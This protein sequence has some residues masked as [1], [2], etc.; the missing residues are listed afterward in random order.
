[1]SVITGP[2]A[3]TTTGATPA[4]GIATLLKNV[5]DTMIFASIYG[6][7]GSVTLKFMGT[8]DG[9]NY[10]P[11]QAI[12]LNTGGVVN[13][14]ISVSDNT[15]RGWRVPC[16]GLTNV[17]LYIVGIGSG[18]VNAYGASGLFVNLPLNSIQQTGTVIGGAQTMTGNLT[19]ADGV[20]VPLGSSSGTKFGTATSQKIGFFNAT[21]VIQQAVTGTTTGFTAGA[22]TGAKSDSTYTGNTG[23]SAYTTGDIVLCLKN[24]GLLAA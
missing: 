20:N 15:V 6:T 5:S 21:P 17:Q 10:F 13:G 11:I 19:L 4:T 9:T 16:D 2:K 7:Y 18:T 3:L 12:D 22:G 14:T 23:S 8:V 1:M 24:L